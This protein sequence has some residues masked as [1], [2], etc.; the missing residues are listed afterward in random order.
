MQLPLNERTKHSLAIHLQQR[1]FRPMRSAFLIAIAVAAASLAAPAAHADSMRCGNRLV[2][3]GD[4]TSSVIAFCG[5]PSDVQRR[6]L[7]RRPYYDV[8]GR[9]VY[10]GDGLEEIL[11]ETWT[12]NFGP[13]KLM[14]R[15]RFVD[16]VVDE[17]ETLG[18][19]YN[20]PKRGTYGAGE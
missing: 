18:Y 15:I 11:V 7:L 20:D 6:T 3:D 14:R 16:G 10:F 9:L 19:G 1:I 5:E 13:H 8:R 4:P 2:R 17:V 12:Y